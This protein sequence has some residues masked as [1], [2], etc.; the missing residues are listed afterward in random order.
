VSLEDDLDS[1]KILDELASE[2]G[3]KTEPPPAVSDA[4][5]AWEPPE[6][7]AFDSN[8]KRIVPDSADKAKTWLSQ[9][10]NY[11][12]RM[13]EFN[14]KRSEFEAK[15]KDWEPRVKRWEEVDTYARENPEWWQH[16][17]SQ[18]NSRQSPQRPPEIAQALAPIEEK[19]GKYESMLSAWEKEKE[20]IQFKQQ[21]S[22]LDL[23]VDS[24]RK[25]HA[26]IDLASVDD[27]GRSLEARVYAH[28]TENGIPTFRAAFYDLMSDKLLEL[29]SAN[30]REA[31]AKEKASQAKAGIMGQSPTPVKGQVR[32]AENFRKK[33]YD[34]L[35]HEAM[36]E[37]RAAR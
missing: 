37:I 20:E 17:E 34:D 30:A 5:K 25:K 10:H 19:L 24:I 23:E 3:D 27:S 8:G 2:G 1:Q 26:N 6:W 13:A 28:A 22:A 11:S 31:A 15:Q 7:A 16:V 12:Q 35:A 21:E 33:S 18:W 36:E 32:Q 29:S 9:G 14:R 4:P